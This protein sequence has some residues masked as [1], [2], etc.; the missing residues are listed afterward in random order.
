MAD[1][2]DPTL[3]LKITGDGKD[4][5]QA[6]A[7]VETAV[8]KV[9]PAAHKAAAEVAAAG[10]RIDAALSAI[11]PEAA[12]AT[13]AVGKVGPAA[14]L[15]ASTLVQ[16][17][18]QSVRALV[19]QAGA[20]KSLSAEGKAQLVALAGQ[21]RA[22]AA[23]IGG[24]GTTATGS[25]PALAQMAASGSAALK[26]LESQAQATGRTL[27]DTLG[28]N[29]SATTRARSQAQATAQATQAAND[30]AAAT[31]AQA[32]AR[33]AAQSLLD[34]AQAASAVGAAQA[35]A[36]QSARSLAASE[37]DLAAILAAI[38]TPQA[39]HAAWLA[40]TNALYQA[41]ALSTTEYH[42]ALAAGDA[43]L[44]S[45]S[46][47]Q[48]KLRG[49][50]AASL[51]DMALFTAGYGALSAA[52]SAPTA[53]AEVAVQQDRLNRLMVASSGSTE[54][55]AKDYA[56]ARATANAL[57]LDLVA[58][59]TAFG[60]FNAS[61]R[62]SGLESAQ[63]RDI[64]AG[65]STA[66]AALGLSTEDASG[67]LNAIGQMM[68]KGTIQAEE[69]RGQLGDRL[70]GTLQIMAKALGVPLPNL[71]KMLETGQLVASEVLPQFGAAMRREF[72]AASFDGAAA[73]IA[74]LNNAWTETKEALVSSEWVADIA[75]GLEER[76]RAITAAIEE[77]QKAAKRNDFIPDAIPTGAIPGAI[78]GAATGFLVAGPVGL[79]IGGAAGYKA[80]ANAMDT[81][82][83]LDADR[84]AQ[85][86]MADNQRRMDQLFPP[87]ARGP[88]IRINV[89][90]DIVGDLEKIQKEVQKTDKVLT[91]SKIELLKAQ[92]DYNA[93]LALE[94]QQKGLTGAE[95]QQ[96]VQTEL[97]TIHAKE[98][99]T[100]ATK[101]QSEADK[102]RAQDLRDSLKAITDQFETERR[103]SQQYREQE[104]TAAG[105][106]AQKRL[107]IEQR[108]ATAARQSKVEELQAQADTLQRLGATNAT[109][110]DTADIKSRILE[111]QREI[112]AEQKVGAAESKTYA[113]KFKAQAQ[114]QQ[115]SLQKLADSAAAAQAK[116]QAAQA[117]QA[118]GGDAQAIRAAVDATTRRLDLEQQIA[119]TRQKYSGDAAAQAQAEA[120]LRAQ[121]DATQKMDALVRDSADRQASYWTG[122]WEQAG[123]NVH[124]AL[125]GMFESLLTGQARGISGLFRQIRQL[126]AN[127][128]SNIAASQVEGWIGSALFGG[129]G[130]SILG[131]ATGAG[132][133]AATV[134][135][136][137]AG[138]AGGIAASSG[139]GMV[140][141][142]TGGTPLL[143]GM[144]SPFMA[145]M[146]LRLGS[147]LGLSGSASSYLGMAGYYSPYGAVAGLTANLLG[148]KGGSPIANMVLPTVGGLAG[149]A[150]GGAATAA[151][152]AALGA[153]AGAAAG[154]I[155]AVIGALVGAAASM[156]FKA[157]KPHGGAAL[158][159]GADNSMSVDWTK[160]HAGSGAANMAGWGLAVAPTFK[161]IE[162]AFGV[163]LGKLNIGLEQKN[164]DVYFRASDGSGQFY[165]NVSRVYSKKGKAS[166]EAVQDQLDQLAAAVLKRGD[167]LAQID[168]DL[169]QGAIRSSDRL[170]E[171]Q[172]KYKTVLNIRSF[173]GE[174]TNLGQTVDKLQV[175]YDRYAQRVRAL[176]NQADREPE[177]AKLADAFTRQ[178]DTQVRGFRAALS[179]LAGGSG[180][181]V[182]DAV[183]NLVAQARALDA[184]N[185]ELAAAA[186]RSGG[187]LNY[188]PVPDGAIQA[189]LT[190]GVTDQLYQLA[191]AGKPLAEQLAALKATF[192]SLEKEAQQAGVA[193]DTVTAAEQAAVETLRNSLTQPL[194]DQI[195]AD[196]Q[197]IQDA[198]AGPGATLTRLSADIGA[199][200]SGLDAIFD[201]AAQQTQVEKVIGLVQRRYQLEMSQ[202][203][204]QIQ[205]AQGLK[206]MA[207]G[208][209][210]SNISPL[211]PKERFDTAQS[212]WLA[213]LAKYNGGDHG[214]DLIAKL[215]T[216]AQGY[217]Q[218]AQG[219]ASRIDYRKIF[220]SVTQTLDRLGG[221]ATDSAQQQLAGIVKDNN[222]VLDRLQK[223]LT[224]AEDRAKK[225][226]N[227]APDLMTDLNSIATNIDKLTRSVTTK[228][229]AAALKT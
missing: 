187:K 156:L 27:A 8:G 221:D 203:Q 179:A 87:S 99:E 88:D 33:A 98:A 19:E 85:A 148:M 129:G 17:S 194:R 2:R 94:A 45:A 70:P 32:A 79:V 170:S 24:I 128:L 112:T 62:G 162:N 51:K 143:T 42:A 192:P 58:T 110:S 171:I 18:N 120:S 175:D 14:A 55:A 123:R 172:R 167:V 216:D 91:D 109:E 95:A 54:Q 176:T 213:D 9:G 69:L 13:A 7:A 150:I 212:T 46:A 113:D 10:G 145:G 21:A 61:A 25:G 168:D 182:A 121:S 122:A 190:Q 86:S 37:A 66:A 64:F 224:A 40:K 34:Q 71:N 35:T 16:S 206:D 102:R 31:Q 83:G 130:A 20:W 67:A 193:L 188:T 199:A 23:E 75:K 227:Y 222:D 191:G 105:D 134:G 177:L 38:R 209:R 183:A 52:L 41:G 181:T 173:E 84:A 43:R 60:K 117:A 205:A 125:A 215:G 158:T 207:T 155:G 127:V 65:V 50:F 169:V 149:G 226:D 81:G 56:F 92:K 68:S 101:A 140:G 208:L 11:A 115:E 229:G 49:G 124:D 164:R 108:Y 174:R 104:L 159:F 204:A 89:G 180:N 217:L 119:Q 63:V 12:Q 28:M 26:S 219:Y 59:A 220:N 132:T 211:T 197:A 186:K 107:E 74:R 48:D 210:L 198:L 111:L 135:A 218:E 73:N 139:P 3:H 22:T 103:E 166:P 225:Q 5:A 202:L 195:A 151:V 214:A 15:A 93:A 165:E 152:T 201:P 223:V 137:T 131:A 147:A 141:Y 118:N 184:Q 163:E 72:S 53:I 185:R 114:A 97:A 157:G 76:L 106:N 57:G 90:G 228:T 154:P 136:A 142:I 116:L 78:G 39:D 144:T 96:Y 44:A 29:G 146:G 189:A 200:L 4:A 36:A 196:A 178:F 161:A 82:T 77:A 6:A 47:G 30:I 153:E 126:S 1:P 80:G 133:G 160:D 100:A 138:T